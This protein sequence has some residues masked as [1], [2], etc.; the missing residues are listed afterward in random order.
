MSKLEKYYFVFIEINAMQC[1]QLCI[2]IRCMRLTN[3]FSIHILPTVNSIVAKNIG[4]FNFLFQ[5]L[6]KRILWLPF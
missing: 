1:N 6:E 3:L 4:V 2:Q 5:I